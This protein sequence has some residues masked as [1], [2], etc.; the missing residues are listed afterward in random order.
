MHL[1]PDGPNLNHFFWITV[2]YICLYY[3]IILLQ[4]CVE[5]TLDDK[6]A[7][8][9]EVD[10]LVEKDSVILFSSATNTPGSAFSVGLGHRAQC[11]VAHTVGEFPIMK[12]LSPCTSIY[13]E[14]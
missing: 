5:D 11:L 10:S 6:K 1:I 4:V 9:K 14:G 3:Y 8:L 2:L 12:S 7:F 13:L